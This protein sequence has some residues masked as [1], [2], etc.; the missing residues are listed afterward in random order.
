MPRKKLI[1]R[2]EPRYGVSRD[3]LEV[4]TKYVARE[5]EDSCLYST[6]DL[7]ARLAT[8]RAAWAQS[9]Q[10]L[11]NAVRALPDRERIAIQCLVARDL[12][13]LIE[14]YCT[15]L[16]VP[17]APPSRLTRSTSEKAPKDEPGHERMLPFSEWLFAPD[18]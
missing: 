5:F 7:T 3:M 18:A 10:V 4:E 8:I 11:E 17:S 2:F 9:D 14:L 16:Q 13:H 12:F 6:A 15:Y 1:R